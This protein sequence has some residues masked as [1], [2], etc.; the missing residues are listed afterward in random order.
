[1]KKALIQTFAVLLC[2]SL[3]V[4]FCACNKPPAEEHQTVNVTQETAPTEESSQPSTEEASEPTQAQKPTTAEKEDDPTEP[5]P[6]N[7]PAEKSITFD[8]KIQKIKDVFYTTQAELDQYT[9]KYFG[10][11]ATGY[12]KNGSL[13][14]L[15]EYPEYNPEIDGYSNGEKEK[16]FYYEDGKL[17]FIFLVDANTGAEDRLYYYDGKLIRWIDSSSTTHESKAKLKEM[18]KWY[19]YAMEKYNSVC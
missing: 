1:M 17:F 18:D 19:S 4:C 14:M 3:S 6:T 5:A 16:F 13:R 8:E 10:T 7:K 2:L 11:S 9:E 12:Y 15:N